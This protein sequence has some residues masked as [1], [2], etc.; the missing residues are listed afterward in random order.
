MPSNDEFPEVFRRLRAIIAPYESRMRVTADTDAAYA[1]D[2]HHVMANGKPLFFASVT[3]RKN[4]V[5]FHL[6]PV[7]AFP[8]L[9]D[10]AGELR[11]RMQ[12]KSCFNFRHT[13][14]AQLDALDAL[15]RRGY[16]RY[17][18]EGLLGGA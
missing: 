6:M 9:L 12:G 4:Y 15:V 14:D 2:T 10:D 8:E 11:K 17:A 13:D 7:Y 5:S 3:V 1:L 18:A 16:E